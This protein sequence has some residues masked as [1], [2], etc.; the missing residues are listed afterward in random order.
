ML[1]SAVLACQGPMGWLRNKPGCCW[2]AGC[3]AC[4]RD[5][6]HL[7]HHVLLLEGQLHVGDVRLQRWV[8]PHVAV[9]K[10]VPKR[11]PVLLACTLRL[12]WGLKHHKGLRI[13][14]DAKAALVGVVFL[15]ATSA[16]AAAGCPTLA[17]T[18][19]APS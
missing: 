17:A 11:L 19:A 1:K 8:H 14:M 12:F 15:C 4:L 2:F 5:A 9:P 10:L 7:L 3:A 18:T 16:T 6:A 13:S